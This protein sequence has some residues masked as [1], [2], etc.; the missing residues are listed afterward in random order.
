MVHF[1][2]GSDH[3]PLNKLLKL[4][5]LV[6]SGGEA[7]A[8]ISAGEVKVNGITETQKRKKLRAGNEVVFRQVTIVVT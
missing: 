6:E 2:E 7:N 8:V 5:N 3:I 4:F 1:L